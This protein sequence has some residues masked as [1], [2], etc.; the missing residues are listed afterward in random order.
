ME[1]HLYSSPAQLAAK[2]AEY[3]VAIGSKRTSKM[4]H[5][6]FDLEEQIP[7]PPPSLISRGD[8]FRK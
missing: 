6:L 3:A 7:C 5:E 2:P 4:Q 8:V 1:R